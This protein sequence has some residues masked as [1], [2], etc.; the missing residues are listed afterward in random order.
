MPSPTKARPVK[1]P[2]GLTLEQ[3][4]ALIA[5]NCLRQIRANEAGLR[6]SEEP[7]F[8]HQMR[9][10][11]RRLRS[12]L[13]LFKPWIVL[14]P[15]LAEEIAW[16]GQTLGAARDA[17]VLA[18]TTLPALTQACV[19]LEDLGGLQ[20]AAANLAQRRRRQAVL[21]LNSERYLGLMAGLEGWLKAHGWRTDSPR[22][23]ELGTPL[24]E[25]AKQMLKRRREKLQ[26]QA[27]ALPE[28]ASADARHR[29][30][31]AVK[32]LRYA[33]DFFRALAAT[34]SK[35]RRDQITALQELLG[36]LNDA[37][38]GRGLLLELGNKA[39]A[40]PAAFVRGVLW[41]QSQQRIVELAALLQA[42]SSK[43]RQIP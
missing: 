20:K 2:A 24:A 9:V 6:L 15:E 31:I 22:P 13:G 16:L 11:L 34:P 41:A 35:A 17:E 21:A 18:G 1:L 38:V 14:P 37:E 27:Q 40:G 3:G 12:A 36:Q 25:A 28:Q 26:K 5:R 23:D 33:G 30:R 7:E 8:V 4:F 39:H 29:V 42:L 43:C 10:G 32:K 19:D